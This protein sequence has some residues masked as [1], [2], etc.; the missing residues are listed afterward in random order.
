MLIHKHPQ[1]HT[2]YAVQNDNHRDRECWLEGNRV[3]LPD[4]SCITKSEVSHR[5][6]STLS[7]Q[8]SRLVGIDLLFLSFFV[9][10]T[11]ENSSF[12]R[13][14]GRGRDWARGCDW[15]SGPRSRLTLAE[16]ITSTGEMSTKVAAG[17]PAGVPR[18]SRNFASSSCI[19]LR[20]SAS[21]IRAPPLAYAYHSLGVLP[22]LSVGRG[23]L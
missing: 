11:Y 20:A 5:P 8:S 22:E 1:A 4:A 21:S 17:P 18:S 3:S 13:I 23:G 10:P 15:N 9:V 19:F 14:L 7:P 2:Q 6:S 16:A 12:I